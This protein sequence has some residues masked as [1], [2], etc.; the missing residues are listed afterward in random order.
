MIIFAYGIVK[1]ASYKN[2]ISHRKCDLAQK[3]AMGN[4]KKEEKRLLGIEKTHKK[5]YIYEVYC[6]VCKQ[7]KRSL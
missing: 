7:K 6:A 5:C 1:A 2:K 3:M 4:N